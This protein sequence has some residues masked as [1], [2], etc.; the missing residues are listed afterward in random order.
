MINNKTNKKEVL[1][2]RSCHNTFHQSDVKEVK[3]ERCGLE[4]NEK[5][6]PFCGGHT[7]G[8]VDYPVN[9]FDLLYKNFYHRNTDKVLRRK[10][11]VITNQII[12]EDTEKYKQKIKNRKFVE[13]V[14]AERMAMA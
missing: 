11:N 10:L 2:C 9:E 4:I 14:N 12:T 13:Q 8:L 5:V 7:Y 3:T 6:C 1:Q